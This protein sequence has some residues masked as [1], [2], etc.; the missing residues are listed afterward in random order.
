MLNKNTIQFFEDRHKSLP[1]LVERR[2]F[3]VTPPQIKKAAEEFYGRIAEWHSKQLTMKDD[4]VIDN[5]D[6]AREV[7]AIAKSYANE[8]KQ[9]EEDIEVFEHS[10]EII[11]ELN[12]S[13]ATLKNKLTTAK[14]DYAQL[15]LEHAALLKTKKCRELALAIAVAISAWGYL[16]YIYCVD[17]WRAIKC[18]I[19]M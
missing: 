16:G 10:K 9:F 5:I 2:P 13:K 7:F 19:P 11:A 17:L 15:R 18:L 12:I 6:I 14:K 1:L 8:S 3:D 4:R